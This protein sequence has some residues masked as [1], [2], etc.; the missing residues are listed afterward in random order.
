MFKVICICI[1]VFTFLLV[2]CNPAEHMSQ[3]V[4]EDSIGE[5]ASSTA[6]NTPIPEWIYPGNQYFTS[7]D[8]RFRI[9][10]DMF[11][12]DTFTYAEDKDTYKTWVTSTVPVQAIMGKNGYHIED[13]YPKLYSSTNIYMGQLNDPPKTLWLMFDLPVYAPAMGHQ[14]MYFCYF[15][16]DNGITWDASNSPTENS[17]KFLAAADMRVDGK[18]CMMLYT[19]K[20]MGISEMEV[21]YTTN[22]GETWDILNSESLVFP[23]GYGASDYPRDIGSCRITDHD[24]IQLELTV[25][26][27]YDLELGR[28]CENLLYEYDLYSHQWRLITELPAPLDTSGK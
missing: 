8:M 19:N 15:S 18:G 24:T 9:V 20:S 28:M 5:V 6:V 16:K 22:F 23:K 11:Y 7:E 1:L 26:L 21:F 17:S 10:D 2:A 13:I 27:I 4:S 3:T 14:T 12:W 25:E